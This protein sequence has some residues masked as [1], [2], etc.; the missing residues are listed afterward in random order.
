MFMFHVT[1]AIYNTKTCI[2]SS[3]IFQVPSIALQNMAICLRGRE[4]V[5]ADDADGRYR[6]ISKRTAKG[7]R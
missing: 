3:Y 4:P 2:V 7:M 1:I 6:L 5:V